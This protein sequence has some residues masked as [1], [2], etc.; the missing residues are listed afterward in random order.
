M[1]TIASGLAGRGATV[2][3]VTFTREA[4]SHPLR[5]P[6]WTLTVLDA[7]KGPWPLLFWRYMRRARPAAVLLADHRFAVAPTLV[8]RI[9]CP[10]AKVV[11]VLHRSPERL[12]AGGSHM[13]ASRLASWRALLSIAFRA[14][15]TLVAV[16][17]GVRLETI[18]WLRLSESR[19]VT[20]NNPVL[21][22][23][24]TRAAAET[25]EHAW[26]DRP[27]RP[28]VLGVGRLAQE[29]DW[30][31]LFRAFATVRQHLVARLVLL[32]E[33]PER[34]RLE[35]LAVELGLSDD[36]LLAGE[37]SNPYAFMARASV[38]AH[39]ALE[40]G[41][42]TVLIE[43]LGLNLPV[44]AT[45][46]PSGPSEILERGRWGRLVPMRDAEAMAAALLRA[47]A[48][49]QP[50][51]GAREAMWARFS[52][53]AVMEAYGKLLFREGDNAGSH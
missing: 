51:V 21:S 13:T 43:A 38:L 53:E 19:T 36:L 49:G 12:L 32:G 48:E 52:V 37:V 31:T 16:S 29:K 44:V 4:A 3:V 47:V 25:T 1:A 46:C 22:S 35:R 28:V 42:P 5:D 39:A 41:L 34:P 23:A 30:G 45:D 24:V 2:E 10:A 6:R 20:I 8:A 50:P 40:E 33:G 7:S 15:T 17:D 9:A 14:A 11:V 26:F 18:R 27:D